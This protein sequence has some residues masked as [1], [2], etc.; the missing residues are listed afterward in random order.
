MVPASTWQQ[1]GHGLGAVEI[2]GLLFW[3]DA[4][5]LHVLRSCLLGCSCSL[6]WYMV[7]GPND[8][9]LRHIWFIPPLSWPG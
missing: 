5:Q 6:H 8:D 3:D 7:L 2:C 9:M 1:L 4:A